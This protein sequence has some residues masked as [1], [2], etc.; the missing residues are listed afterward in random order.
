LG[1]VV[2]GPPFLERVD[3]V[4]FVFG[5]D[6]VGGLVRALGDL[7]ELGTVGDPLLAGFEEF[8]L[9]GL[10]PG[11]PNPGQGFG[12]RGGQFQTYGSAPHLG[13]DGGELVGVALVG[14]CRGPG[15]LVQALRGLG[16]LVDV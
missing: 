12:E 5:P 16:E 10:G 13:V 1:A 8:L 11:Q 6:A 9:V 2:F 4:A 15:P 7:L 14:L 3:R